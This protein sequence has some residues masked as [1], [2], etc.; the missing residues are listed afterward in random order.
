MSCRDDPR[1][2]TL[3]G[4]RR[5]GAT[6][7]AIN[8]FCRE[9]GITR[10][11]NRMPL[12]R[13]EHFIRLDLDATS[14]RVMAV[15]RPLR[16][17]FPT[18]PS[19]LR[20]SPCLPLPPCRFM[21]RSGTQVVITNLPENHFEEKEA[22][23]FPGRSEETYKVPFTRVVY[24]EATDFRETDSKGYY[25]M[26]PGKSV[27]LR[28]IPG[29]VLGVSI[30]QWL[31]RNPTVGAG[32]CLYWERSSWQ[33]GRVV[34]RQQVPSGCPWRLAVTGADL[35]VRGRAEPRGGGANGSE[36]GWP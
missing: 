12:H 32:A 3:A 27:M 5:R 33:P 31:P 25:G 9:G 34:T 26:A 21:A 23:V 22:S 11:D 2:L 29:E 28:L 13:L 17:R 7:A 8:T 36:P 14:P 15:I 20:R 19:R 18:A 35:V 30:L 4:L 1:L 10:S 16:V 6:P 24:I